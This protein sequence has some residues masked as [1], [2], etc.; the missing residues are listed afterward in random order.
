MYK[1]N[2]LIFYFSEG[3]GGDKIEDLCESIGY[4]ELVDLI[5]SEGI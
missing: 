4:L 3:Q 1:V 5:Y 2:R